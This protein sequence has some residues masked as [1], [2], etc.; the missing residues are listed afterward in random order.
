MPTPLDTR[1]EHP[2]LDDLRRLNGVIHIISAVV[3]LAADRASAR[4]RSLDDRDQVVRLTLPSNRPDAG[5][6]T[7]TAAQVNV[8][9]L[10]A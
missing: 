1:S 2:L 5:S 4:S 9:R 7:G 3:L 6:N 10:S 8:H